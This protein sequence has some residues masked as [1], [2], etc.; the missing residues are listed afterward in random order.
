MENVMLMRLSTVKKYN[1][2]IKRS[3]RIFVLLIS[4]VCVMCVTLGS[5]SQS[6]EFIDPDGKRCVVSSA[7]FLHD[8]QGELANHLQHL[9]LTSATTISEAEAIAD[10]VRD[11]R[12]TLG[13]SL[14]YIRVHSGAPVEVFNKLREIDFRGAGL[15]AFKH[16][17]VGRSGE[18]DWGIFYTPSSRPV[19]IPPRDSHTRGGGIVIINPQRTVN[20]VGRDFVRDQGM[21]AGGHAARDQ[22]MIAGG[23]AARDQGRLLR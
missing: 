2:I 11:S 6:Q 13:S 21:I 22:G 7:S 16:D 4:A 10:F 8:H 20:I 17:G 1:S 9:W 12:A 23:H 5:H 18:G 19:V 14:H 3:E 15:P